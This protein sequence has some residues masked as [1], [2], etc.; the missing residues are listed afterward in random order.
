MS[1]WDEYRVG[2]PWV[3]VEWDEVTESFLVDLYFDT[4]PLEAQEMHFALGKVEA[5]QLYKAIQLAFKRLRKSVKRSADDERE[6]GS[7]V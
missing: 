4:A 6:K 5:Q 3:Q 1:D 2:H 7:D